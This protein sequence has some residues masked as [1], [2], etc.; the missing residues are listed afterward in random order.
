MGEEEVERVLLVFDNYIAHLE[1]S[2]FTE[3]TTDEEVNKVMELGHFVEAAVARATEDN[4][5]ECLESHLRAR[6][7]RDKKRTVIPTI[8]QLRFACDGM[9]E[10]YLKDP[11]V[12]TLAMDKILQFYGKHCGAERLKNLLGNLL[13]ISMSTNVIFESLMNLGIPETVVE[14]ETILGAWKNEVEC[15][16]VDRVSLCIEK[17]VDE[18]ELDKL[19]DYA[20]SLEDE[21]PVRNLIMQRL[22][23]LASDYEPNLFAFLTN[24]ETKILRRLLTYPQFQIYFFDAIFYFGRNMQFRDNSWHSEHEF[25][26][27]DLVR[28]LKNL[29]RSSD[30]LR[31]IIFQRLEHAKISAT[32]S[33]WN[34]VE[35]DTMR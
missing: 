22:S 11:D 23:T 24:L 10:V 13:E 5:T 3:S 18:G 27:E 14:D 26:Y 12:P 20:S 7:F 32:T 6:W 2:G 17:M 31:A 34:D 29:S 9:V 21:S 35:R 1:S 8:S 19:I 4:K 30:Q 15:G 33:V 25:H 16:K 28:T